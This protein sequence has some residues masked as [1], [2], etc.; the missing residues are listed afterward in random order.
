MIFPDLQQKN[1]K[2]QILINYDPK[3]QQL[4][5]VQ[6]RGGREATMGISRK[7]GHYFFRE[8]AVWLA[9][10]G[11]ATI[12][13]RGN[14]LLQPECYSLLEAA[15]ISPAK[16]FAYSY[17]KRAGYIVFPYGTL[18][19]SK[20][21]C[22]NEDLK[23]LTKPEPYFPRELLDQFP[24]LVSR[25]LTITPLHKKPEIVEKFNLPDA[26]PD[27][28]LVSQK[29]D[30]E[31]EARK[32]SRE[33]LRP[34]HWPSFDKFARRVPTWSDYR[35]QKTKALEK[36]ENPTEKVAVLLPVDYDV[37]LGD[38]SF[39]RSS[40]LPAYRLIV[41]SDLHAP[42]PSVADLNWLSSQLADS[43]LLIAL[44]SNGSILF[45]DV[46]QVPVLL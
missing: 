15:M 24:S 7:D 11:I 40:S 9:E 34:R 28:K 18:L 10:A 43:R 39:R 35:L 25:K 27:L 4:K 42:L 5:A 21:S 23:Y 33:V 14:A 29:V 38:G 3:H 26:F 22:Q 8:E 30:A 1:A 46:N 37:Y 20:G 31:S 19:C 44:V 13:C 16:Y 41:I 36:C 12:L 2:R 32:H 6:L 17:L 45:Y